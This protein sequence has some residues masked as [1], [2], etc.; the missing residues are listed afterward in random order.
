MKEGFERFPFSAATFTFGLK[1]MDLF[2]HF[3]SKTGSLSCPECV[4]QAAVG[5][6]FTDLTVRDDTSDHIS[7]SM[8]NPTEVSGRVWSASGNKS[9]FGTLGIKS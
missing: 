7:V 2:A 1:D 5:A 8:E 6:F 3:P 9:T 4:I